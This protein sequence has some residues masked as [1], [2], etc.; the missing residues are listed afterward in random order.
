MPVRKEV[1]PEQTPTVPKVRVD[2]PTRYP[3]TEALLRD[4]RLTTQDVLEIA[5]IVCPEDVAAYEQKKTRKALLTMVLENLQF[6]EGSTEDHPQ[7]LAPYWDKLSTKGDSSKP[8]KDDDDDDDSPK[9]STT[10]SVV[11]VG[12]GTVSYMVG[13]TKNTGDFNSTKIQ[14]GV[15]LPIDASAELIAK[16]NPTIQICKDKV[17]ETLTEDVEGIISSFK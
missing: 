4:D 2:K 1:L 3:F 6:Y 5:E 11:N 10:S 12:A 17:I 9:V 14:V 8:A 16:I 15:T 13:I 7:G